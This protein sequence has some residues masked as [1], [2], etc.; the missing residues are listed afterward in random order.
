M[1]RPL[2]NIANVSYKF[3]EQ[4]VEATAPGHARRPW[5]EPGAEGTGFSA[6]FMSKTD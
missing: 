3:M 5:G 4:A 1:L 2:V 6:N